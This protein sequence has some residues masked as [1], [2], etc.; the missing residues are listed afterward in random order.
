MKT[1]T[2][3]PPAETGPDRLLEHHWRRLHPELSAYLCRLVL[4]PALAEELAQDA[5]E[6]GGR[7]L[8]GGC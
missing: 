2:P 1:G 3:V 7:F 6:K 8:V 4:R 5:L